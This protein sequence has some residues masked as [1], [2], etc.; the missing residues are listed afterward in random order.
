[1]RRI[2]DGDGL[3]L[4]DRLRNQSLDDKENNNN[5]NNPVTSVAQD[6]EQPLFSTIR[7]PTL[8]PNST[9]FRSTL[10]SLAEIATRKPVICKED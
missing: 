1:M 10:R 7:P 9:L 2:S 6:V 4:V 5:S 8:V 3:S